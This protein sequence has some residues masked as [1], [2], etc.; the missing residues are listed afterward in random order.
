[1]CVNVCVVAAVASIKGQF[2]CL[3]CLNSTKSIKRR[4]RRKG[5]VSEDTS[6]FHLLVSFSGSLVSFTRCRAFTD[7]FFPYPTSCCC[8]SEKLQARTKQ[9]A[10]HIQ[11]IKQDSEDGR[12]GR[13]NSYKQEIKTN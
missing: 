12:K 3:I 5:E 4:S 1:M 2:I 11:V 9:R 10:D 6:L 8:T 13:R 7:R